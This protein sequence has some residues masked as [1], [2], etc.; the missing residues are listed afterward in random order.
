MC[1]QDDIC[2]MTKKVSFLNVGQIIRDIRIHESEKNVCLIGIAL[3]RQCKD[4]AK[5]KSY[6]LTRNII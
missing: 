1:T 6:N 2:K 4:S 5:L 3:Y